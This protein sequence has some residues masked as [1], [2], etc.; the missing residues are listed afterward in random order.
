M[1]SKGIKTAM[2]ECVPVRRKPTPKPKAKAKAKAKAKSKMRPVRKTQLK[3]KAHDCARIKEAKVMAADVRSHR[4]ERLPG[5]K[6]LF[7]CLPNVC[8]HHFP[9]VSR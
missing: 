1:A 6:W 2:A 9:L 8:I 3:K 4:G 7:L 5:N